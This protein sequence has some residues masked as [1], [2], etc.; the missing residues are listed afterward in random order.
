VGLTAHGGAAVEARGLSVGRGEAVVLAAVD[1]VVGEGECLALVG[2]NGSGKTTLLRALAG[3]DHPRAGEL[4]W[5]GG[6]LPEGRARVGQVG[7]LFQGE[8]PAPFTVREQVA[9]GLGLDGPPSPAQQRLVDEAL[10]LL[11]LQ[12]VAGRACA[13]LSGG[14]WQRAAVARAMAAGPRLLLLD[15][16]TS[17]LDPARRAGLLA[18]LGRLRGRVAVVLATHDLDC[19]SA[20]DRVALLGGGRIA[21]LGPPAAVLTPALLGEALGVRVRRLDDPRGGRPFLRVEAPG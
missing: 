3:L 20:C 9:L 16:P 21:A 6:A 15:E 14:E 19:A 10:A 4:R 17:Q 7:V 5:A 1:L 12:A 2:A 8:P 18:L 11:D 13:G